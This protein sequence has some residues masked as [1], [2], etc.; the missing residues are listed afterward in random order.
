MKYLILY[1]L[2]PL[3]LYSGGKGVFHLCFGTWVLDPIIENAET[4]VHV[5]FGRSQEEK[6]KS[7][8]FAWDLGSRI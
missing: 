8:G 6:R 7:V 5:H 3:K 2:F 4:L 1:F